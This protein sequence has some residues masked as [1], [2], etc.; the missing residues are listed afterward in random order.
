MFAFRQVWDFFY[1]RYA[2]AGVDG[3]CYRMDRY[4]GTC[5]IAP[6]YGWSKRSDLLPRRESDNITPVNIIDTHATL[7][8]KRLHGV[9]TESGGGRYGRLWATQVAAILVMALPIGVAW[10]WTF[11]EMWP[12]WFPAWSQAGLSLSERLT[13]GESYY[14][15]APLVPIVTIYLFW[16]RAH[17]DTVEYERT[18]AAACFAWI[19]M[20]AML[21]LHVMCTYLRVAVFSGFAFVGF[22]L[23][24]LVWWGGWSALRRYGA[25][26]LLLFFMIPLPM[27]WVHEIGF[28]LKIFAGRM[29]MALVDGVG[30][31]VVLDGS[32][33]HVL[34]RSDNAP[35]TLQLG[36]V[37]GGL[38]SAMSLFWIASVYLT[39]AKSGF[40]GRIIL[41][42]AVLPLAILCNALRISFLIVLAYGFDVSTAAEDGWP[43][44]LSGVAV[45]VLA[46]T[47][48]IFLDY[49]LAKLPHSTRCSNENTARKNFART[50]PLRA[51]AWGVV[52]RW[53]TVVL[54][55]V[56]MMCIACGEDN[57]HPKAT[58]YAD[59][60]LP[61]SFDD[62][63]STYL[64]SDVSVP[65]RTQAMLRTSDYSFRRY[66]TPNESSQV[67][68]LVVF[69][70]QHR[71][72]IH[73]PSICIAGSGQEIVSHR[74]VA[75]KVLGE[76]KVLFRELITQRDGA[77]AC[78]LFTYKYG[79]HYT[80]NFTQQQLGVLTQRII[81][82]DSAGALI[83]FSVPPVYNQASDACH[84]VY[85]AA[86]Q[87]MPQIEEA[88][89]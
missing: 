58:T 54:S 34:A 68:A 78:H 81:G 5:L 18:R 20:V 50:R 79:D 6:G 28:A 13:S 69:G 53:P 24:F 52:C 12:R 25:V 38:R 11:G 82:K 41:I 2:D 48:M 45:F 37:C 64:A 74:D 19:A 30:L 49:L 67:D 89:P 44:Q 3:L 57:L 83:R 22:L 39:M 63:K 31:P 4:V 21:F 84:L 27:H 72:S 75:V 14:S 51:S 17:D 46:M 23:A 71:E 40:M 33:I 73:P 61:T 35:R 8:N 60:A 47:T 36:Q 70:G 80:A 32:Y 88:L 86:E 55:I 9:A 7:E 42:S 65:R 43:H 26:V 87:L 1:R 16:S 66:S 29:G 62:N 77:I 59:T 85:V 10:H 76:T 56:A 15:H